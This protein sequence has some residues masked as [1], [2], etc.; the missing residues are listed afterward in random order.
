MQSAEFDR[1]VADYE[2]Q[3]R[4]SIRLSG[5]GTGYF[6]EYK[7]RELARLAAA[8]GLEAPRIL[9]F[10]AGMG[11]SLPA[12]RRHFR[13][14]R[15]VMA[16]VSAESLRM[17]R[18]LHGGDEPQLL[19]RD[20]RLPAGNGSFDITFTA[21]VFHHIPEEEHGAWL[22]ELRRVT[23]VGGHL[24]IFEHNPLNP[25]TRHAVASCP[26][27]ENAVLIRAGTLRSRV[28]QAGWSHPRTDY[29]LFFPAALA[30][31]RVLEPALRRIALGAQYA[32]HAVNAGA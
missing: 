11:N 30:K 21:C 7:I 19:I 29:Q 6:A 16:D 18:S 22:A 24:V 2:R 9:D 25:L 8:W 27:D 5:E 12:F 26:F 15:I 13:D 4:E 20:G 28:A 1:Y 17:A 3:H 23:A 32:C 31:L 10:G 14:S